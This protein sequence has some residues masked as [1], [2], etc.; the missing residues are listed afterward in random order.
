MRIRV[1]ESK[2]SL[3]GHGRGLRNPEALPKERCIEGVQEWSVQ[4]IVRHCT[5]YPTP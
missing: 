3:R 1:P 4:S 5:D 2:I